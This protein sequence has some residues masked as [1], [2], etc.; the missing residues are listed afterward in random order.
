MEAIMFASDGIQLLERMTGARECLGR[1]IE[2]LPLRSEHFP[3]EARGRE[4]VTAEGVMIAVATSLAM[5]ED[6]ARRLNKSDWSDQEEQ[7]AL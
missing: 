1:S 2:P 4:I 5:S 7:W 3:V 6:I